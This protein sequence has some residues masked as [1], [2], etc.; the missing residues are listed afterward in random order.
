MV[1]VVDTLLDVIR[2]VS[3]DMFVAVLPV[4]EERYD[5]TR[6]AVLQWVLSFAHTFT[7]LVAVPEL[8]GYPEAVT[9]LR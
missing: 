5:S 4:V 8:T 1:D 7:L 2:P 6:V 9:T 3:A